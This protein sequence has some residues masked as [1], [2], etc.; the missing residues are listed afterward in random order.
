MATRVLVLGGHGML[1]HKLWQVATARALETW[2][3]VRRASGVL[4]VPDRA[5]APVEANDMDALTQAVAR[6]RPAVIVNCIG[7][8]KQLPLAADP[9]PS[10]TVNA[11]LPH[12]LLALSN[13]AGARLIHISTDCVFNGQRG[14]YREGDVEDA[15]DL[16]G[17]SKLLGE[18]RGPGLTLRTSMIGREL[19]GQH[20]LVEWFLSQAGPVDGYRRAVFSGVTTIE[21][22]HVIVDLIESHPSLEGL[23]HVAAAPIDKCTL[24]T[25]VARAHDRT[26]AIRAVD[27]PVID[28]SLDGSAF[29]ARTGRRIPDWPTMIREMAAERDQYAEWRRVR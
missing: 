12:R 17:R 9:V 20:G 23:Y 25:D 16:Y 13:A 6:V 10:L 7:V 8:V 26:V 3:T 29:L 21:L 14:A 4:M 24:L 2:A 27:E 28:R 15:G 11:V 19:S 22:S 1:G 5:L 18:V